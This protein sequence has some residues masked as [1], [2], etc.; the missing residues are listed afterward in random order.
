MAVR[1]DDRLL[2]DG[3]SSSTDQ[4]S[5]INRL[6]SGHGTCSEMLTEA[7]VNLMGRGW[8]D[9]WTED[10]EKTDEQ[11]THPMISRSLC[12]PSSSD[13]FVSCSTRICRCFL[14]SSTL[15][16]CLLQW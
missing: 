6:I 13:Y 2:R 5:L 9:G 1:S 12:A 15:N 7:V 8:L 10:V 4:L 14:K 16:V 3:M 11:M